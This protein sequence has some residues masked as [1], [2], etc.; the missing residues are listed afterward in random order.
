[1]GK[2]I[3]LRGTLCRKV[4]KIVWALE[5]GGK[6]PFEKNEKLRRSKCLSDDYSR[7]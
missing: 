2:G 5:R 1:M 4:I 6:K 3:T 7:L